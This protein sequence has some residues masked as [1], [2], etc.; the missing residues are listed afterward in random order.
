MAVI[1]VDLLEMDQEE[2]L[3]RKAAEETRSL[4]WV[5][6][7][8]ADRTGTRKT[9]PTGHDTADDKIYRR[10]DQVAEARR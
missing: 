1:I 8:M 3:F 4:W 7:A 5:T 2:P 9:Y 6:Q 10:H